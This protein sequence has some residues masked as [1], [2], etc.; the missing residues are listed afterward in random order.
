[1]QKEADVY[2]S[3]PSG[4]VSFEPGARF[5]DALGRAYD[6]MKA[7]IKYYVFRDAVEPGIPLEFEVWG[8]VIMNEKMNNINPRNTRCQSL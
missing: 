1:L 5:F 8:K 4:R 3:R 6:K 2:G 7:R